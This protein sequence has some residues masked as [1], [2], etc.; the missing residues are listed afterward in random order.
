MAPILAAVLCAASLLRSRHLWI[1]ALG[2]VL[3]RDFLLGIS[4]FTLVRLVGMAL[5]VAAVYGLKV[6]ATARSLLI[7]LLVVS[8][9]FH[10]ALAVGDW[11]TGTCGIWPMTA[12]GLAGSI[13]TALPYFQQSF[14][15]DL[16]FT[17]LFLGLYGLAAHRLL[18]KTALAASRNG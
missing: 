7:G 2:G 6:R 9:I 12:A 14:I 3:V 18:G 10:L 11:A 16:F 15:G 4:V 17:G 5:V 1:V 13:R 8:P